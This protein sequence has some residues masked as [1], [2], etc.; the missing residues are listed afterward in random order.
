MHHFLFD[1]NVGLVIVTFAEALA[2]LVP[3]LIASHI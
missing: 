2:L 1:T 3:L